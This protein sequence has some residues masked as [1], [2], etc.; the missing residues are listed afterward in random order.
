MD[1]V[2]EVK[3][4]W[5]K[6]RR[7]WV[8]RRVNFKI[9]RGEVVSLLGRNGS[10]KSTLVK[11]V[12]GLI[13]PSRGKV[14]VFGEDVHRGEG[15]YKWRIGVL[16]HENLLYEELTLREN[17]EY[18]ARMYGYQGFE[19][20]KTAF[21]AYEM[22]G[23]GMYENYKVAHLSY[24]WRKRANIV[25]A[26]INNPE[27]LILDEPLSG[28]DEEGEAAV[29]EIIGS[30]SRNRT[31]LFTVPSEELLTSL[32]KRGDM[33]PRILRISGGEVLENVEASK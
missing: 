31:V 22:L 4:L 21:N 17:L 1:E 7:I 27:I 33:E 30:V 11:I 28:L 29:S 9:S 12:A 5:K 14:M 8:L 2:L 16:L 13:R 15:Y 6:Y 32:I 25:R 19:D 20:S 18:Y 24:G 23:L 10:G 3:N 26:L